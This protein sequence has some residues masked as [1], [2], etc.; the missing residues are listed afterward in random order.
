MFVRSVVI[1]VDTDGTVTIR[2]PLTFEGQIVRVPAQLWKEFC[3]GSCMIGNKLILHTETN[4]EYL[5]F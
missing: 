2:Q 5:H 1:G 3:Q 4:N